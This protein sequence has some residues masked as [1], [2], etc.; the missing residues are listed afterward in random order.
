MPIMIIKIEKI[1]IEGE[2]PTIYKKGI[3]FLKLKDEIAVGEKIKFKAIWD[4]DTIS[5]FDTLVWET[6]MNTQIVKV[7]G[8]KG[9]VITVIRDAMGIGEIS[10]E[11]MDEK[12]SVIAKGKT[13]FEIAYG[14][15]TLKE[16]QRI[17]K[18]INEKLESAKVAYGN[19]SLD[20]ALSLY[21]EILSID[22]DN[23]DAKYGLTLVAKAKRTKAKVISLYNKAST[24]FNKGNIEAAYKTIMAIGNYM[25]AF[26][27]EDPWRIKV[28]K[29]K[30]T[31]LS[32][33]TLGVS[34]GKIKKYIA[35]GTDLYIYTGS[36]RSFTLFSKKLGVILHREKE[37]PGFEDKYGLY[38]YQKGV[39]VKVLDTGRWEGIYKTNKTHGL[40][41]AFLK[42]LG[43][44]KTIISQMG[45]GKTPGIFLFKGR[46]K[47]QIFENGIMI[48]ESKSKSIWYTFF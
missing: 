35:P 1:G 40:D 3:G 46:L 24:Y 12:G 14:P 13:S 21:N 23:K 29:L 43:A 36:D 4:K 6:D 33:H 8:E 38:V 16:T 15:E 48:Y 31:I 27:K 5:S 42:V 7:E 26:S 41:L 32:S 39:I 30:K 44:N 17:Q 19:R 20:K 9:E 34:G 47:V 28:S 25:W 10:C 45:K 37:I 22:P 18:E 2:R 11:A